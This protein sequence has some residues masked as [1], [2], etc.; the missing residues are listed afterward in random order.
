MLRSDTQTS[1]MKVT[2]TAEKSLILLQ[3]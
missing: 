1:A 2:F 3:H